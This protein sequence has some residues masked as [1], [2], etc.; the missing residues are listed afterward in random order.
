MNLDLVLLDTHALVWLL[1]DHA[2]L[3]QQAVERA[4]AAASRGTVLVSAI[5]F[6]EMATLVG[7][8]RL[9]LSQPV[10]SWRQRVFQVG[11]EEVAVTGEIGIM[12]AE[13]EDFPA[14]PA[15]RIIA[16]TALTLGA[17]LVT[18][19]R[20]ILEWNGQLSRQDARR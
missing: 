16:A 1:E 6:W 18:A 13:L 17:T 3:G 2:R 20:R 14:D 15:D 5:T 4:D 12:A 9:A 19:D 8:R 10:H 7:K 11:I